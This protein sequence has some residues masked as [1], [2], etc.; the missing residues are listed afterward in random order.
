MK[1][2]IPTITG[3]TTTMWL[4]SDEFEEMLA[5]YW[6]HQEDEAAKTLS[7]KSK[8][9]PITRSPRSLWTSLLAL[10]H[11]VYGDHKRHATPR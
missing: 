6:E 5:R 3:R 1:I 4:N 9:K 8:G 2:G 7:S 11:R 10:P